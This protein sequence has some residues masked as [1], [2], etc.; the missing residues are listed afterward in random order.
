MAP[1]K[2]N[3]DLICDIGELAGLFEKS[4]SL[5]NFLQTAVS[6]VAY[7]MRAAVCSVYLYDEAAQELVLTSTQG[8]SPDS[9][10]RVRLKIGEGLVGQAIMEL[11]AIR[12]GNAFRSPHF[13]YIPGIFEERYQAFL[14]VPIL[15][16]LS[17]VGVLCVQDPVPDYF[18]END[19]KALQAIAA[20]LATVIENAKLLMTLHQMQSSAPAAVE[21]AVAEQE[22]RFV[23]G[24]PAASGFAHGRATI[25]GA[26]NGDSWASGA[27][28]EPATI[29]DFH[30][31][32]ARTEQQLED[33]QRQLEER[34]ADVASM[35]FSAHLLIVK[36]PNFSGAMVR[37][38]REGKTPQEAIGEVV[39][40][41]CHLFAQSANPRLREKEQDVKDLGRRLLRNLGSDQEAGADY[42]GCVIIA[43]E[44]MP[45]D[46]L[47][48]SAQSAEG[49][50][51]I[52]GGATS[53][54]S[55]LARALELPMVI[56][57]SRRLFSLA[58]DRMVL[59]DGDQGTITIDPTPEVIAN[60]RELQAARRV[61][62]QHAAQ[63]PDI[64]WTR[65]G[66]RVRIFAN[67]NML[68]ELKVARQMKAEG[69]G[70]Y[71]SE[72]PFIVR[73][74]FPSEEEQFRVYSR[75]LSEMDG[76]EVQ[77]RTLDIG[78]DKMLSYFPSVNESNPFLGLRALRFSLRHKEIFAQ[79]LRA[80]LRA[81]AGRQLKI[82]FPLVSSVDDFIEAREVVMECIAMLKADGIAHNPSPELGAMIELPSA[83]EVADELAAE[84]DFLSIGGNDLVQYILAVDRTNESISDMYVA[85]HPAVLR[86]L[87]RV[88]VATLA[89]NRPLS[90]CG[91]MASDPKIIPFLLG[92]GI[93]T[94]S[95]DVRQIPRVHNVVSELKLSECRQKAEALLRLG[96]VKDVAAVLGGG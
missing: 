81:G 89:R 61:A 80:F 1:R 5:E 24:V 33:L 63:M 58:A 12:E 6:I 4:T 69:I 71:R 16:G 59:L 70:L 50:L 39:H 10:G 27:P 75:I 30:R 8:L 22:L 45:S 25:Y 38:I 54:V 18:D 85:Y 96:R 68:S 29:E 9:V 2:D 3:V 36:D 46:I 20:Q 64:T 65:D 47:K 88:A 44:L 93:M 26:F 15:R 60:Y 14:A 28:A 72:F 55:I 41:Y 94:L 31:A 82:M 42:A 73:N 77:F 23:R 52:G 57:E 91:E 17:R 49:L 66:E 92:I 95:V 35:I 32:V 34:I 76:H 78:G 74:D 40:Q 67:I 51:L 62:E 84:A 13:K 19:T 43:G 87:K 83:V 11:R 48:L 86:A 90:L 79:Q 53:H 21:H 7:H 56:S 37:L